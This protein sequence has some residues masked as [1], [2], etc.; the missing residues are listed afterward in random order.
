M[1]AECDALATLYTTSCFLSPQCMENWSI[2]T[3]A[4]FHPLLCA[5]GEI[6][7]FFCGFELML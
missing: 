1:G 5:N 7:A 4:Y 6:S 2:S 3:G